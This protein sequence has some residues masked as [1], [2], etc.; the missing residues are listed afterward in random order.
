MGCFIYGSKNCCG[1][2]LICHMLGLERMVMLFCRRRCWCFH[3]ICRH[4]QSWWKNILF[5]YI[6]LWSHCYSHLSMKGMKPYWCRM[7]WRIFCI[8]WSNSMG[9]RGGRNLSLI[10]GWKVLP[11]KLFYPKDWKFQEILII[12]PYQ[13]NKT[14]SLFQLKVMNNPSPIKIYLIYPHN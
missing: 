8:F 4:H 9:M 3:P 11:L 1:I 2:R 7:I 14:I 6:S 10:H 5:F 12:F 13:K